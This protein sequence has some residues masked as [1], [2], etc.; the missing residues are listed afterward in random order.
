MN[1]YNR[2]MSLIDLFYPKFCLNCSFPGA[3][4][5]PRC[6][7]YLI[8]PKRPQCY[9]CKKNSLNSLTHQLCLRKLDID[10]VC[11]LFYYNGLLKK[12]IKNFKYRL[13]T[14]VGYELF[15]VIK[16]NVINRLS[17]YKDLNGNVVL[18]PIPLSK[19]KFNER[20]FNQALLIAKF[21]NRYL[22][23]T[24]ADFLTRVKETKPQANMKTKLDRFR[25][26]KGAF[27]IKPGT[28]TRQIKKLRIILIDDV[29]TTGSTVKEAAKVLKKNGALKVYVLA[30][31]GG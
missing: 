3:Y 8:M 6:Q 23:L 20:G 13:A 30:L 9:V 24:I 18:Q 17:F 2:F 19:D 21:M 12:I 11:Y 14:K 7:K 16:P 26:L 29:I 5:C 25:N 1:A 15:N 31:A 28:D 10:G 4:I 27:G 22:N